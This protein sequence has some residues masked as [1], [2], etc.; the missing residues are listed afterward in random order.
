[1]L[2]IYNS[3]TQKKEAFQPIV[4]G[5]IS[6][7]VCGN[8]VYDDCHI[9][10]GR[11][12]VVFDAIVRF[13]RATG[14]KVKYVRNITDIDD[15]IIQRAQQNQESIADLT[16]RYIVRMQ[17]DTKRLGVY[18]PDQEP[19]ATEHIGE[20]I[21]MIARLQE[22][23]Y[24]YLGSGGDVYFD[25]KRYAAYGE[26]AHKD[27]TQMQA[28]NRVALAEDKRSS[29]DFVLWKPAKPEE[30]HWNSP[31]G[32]GRPGWHIECSAMSTKC[33]GDTFDIHGGGADLAFPHHENERAQSEGATG[34][35]FVN[36]WMHVGFVQINKEKMSKS[37][38]N[39]FTIREVFS[40][41]DPE[42]VRYFLLSSHYRYPMNYSTD[43]LEQAQSALERLYLALRGIVLPSLPVQG[44]YYA[45]FVQA[46]Q[47]DFNTPIALSVL[48]D[49]VRELNM[50][51]ERGD[52]AQIALAGELCTVANMIGLLERPPEAF[53]R[54]DQGVDVALIEKL[55]SERT[56]ARASKEWAKSD[57][58]RDK[59]ASMGVILED[60]P[61][62]TVWRKG[63]SEN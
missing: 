61:Q 27:L 28:G 18:S 5:E 34:K 60:G 20:M 62:G 54:S 39:F 4:P 15:K 14:W 6:L 19:R 11:V 35:K 43:S 59:L 53:L 10:H 2:Q 3:L 30:P 41:Y 40:Q 51:R 49:I 24:A 42:V 37:L 1:M 26:L 45:R 58:I 44:N 50:A 21:A 47:D 52:A 33:L 23:G 55:I 29:L 25:V 8:T 48:F 36:I 38:N 17:E 7:Y 13:L 57:A 56:A 31:W 22:R 46:M 16:S 9:G 63:S 12:F 32:H